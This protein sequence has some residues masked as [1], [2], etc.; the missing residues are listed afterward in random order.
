MVY[1]HGAVY[2]LNSKD[3]VEGTVLYFVCTRVQHTFCIYTGYFVYVQGDSVHST[4]T[5]Y[6]VLSICTRVRCTLYHIYKVT[7]YTV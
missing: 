2:I 5:K 3:T 7:V 6:R 1:L 4:F